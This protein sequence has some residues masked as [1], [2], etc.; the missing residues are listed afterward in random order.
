MYLVAEGINLY[1]NTKRQ[2]M[3]P[4]EQTSLYYS[5]YTHTDMTGSVPRIFTK[6]TALH[7]YCLP[8]APL[9]SL[10]LLLLTCT[11]IPGLDNSIPAL[12]LGDFRGG[13]ENL[14]L[15]RVRGF[16][17]IYT[18]LIDASGVEIDLQSFN[19]NFLFGL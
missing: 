5:L 12:A 16:F 4:T 18:A 14:A 19:G 7:F 15:E 13:A 10:T 17:A 11:R 2:A 1:A 6:W 3:L 9:G 8:P